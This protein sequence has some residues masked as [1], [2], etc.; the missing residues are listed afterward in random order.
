MGFV[1]LDKGK[2][3]NG[4]LV[5]SA[6]SSVPSTQ[7][8]AGSSAI[9]GRCSWEVGRVVEGPTQSQ[10]GQEKLW[11]GCLPV[12]TGVPAWGT[13]PCGLDPGPPC[14]EVPWVPA[15]VSRGG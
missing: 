15:H 1:H 8:P 13:R 7:G 4:G 6:P 14:P 9:Q 10:P 3:R 2:P 11:R 5:L 12:L